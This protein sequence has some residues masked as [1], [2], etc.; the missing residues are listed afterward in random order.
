[1]MRGITD[2][3]A[4]GMSY[5]KLDLALDHL[6]GGLSRDVVGGAGVTEEQLELVRKMKDLSEWKR[7]ARTKPFPADGGPHGTLRTEL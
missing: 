2:E 6:A 4:M 3:Y 1:M 5:A 7:G